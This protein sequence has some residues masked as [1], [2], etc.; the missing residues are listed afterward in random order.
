MVRAWLEL[1]IQQNGTGPN[2]KKKDRK[3]KKIGWD[4]LTGYNRIIKLTLAN[5]KKKT[6]KV[7]SQL[8]H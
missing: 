6:I 7:K 3:A 5:F 4:T 2:S 8:I 1:D